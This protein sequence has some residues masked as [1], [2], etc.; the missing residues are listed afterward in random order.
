MHHRKENISYS[1]VQEYVLGQLTSECF[2][3]RVFTSEI[4][5]IALSMDSTLNWPFTIQKWK[6]WFLL[7]NMPHFIKY[8]L[9]LSIFP[10][11][12][13][14]KSEGKCSLF[15]KARKYLHLVICSKCYKY[16]VFVIALCKDLHIF[17]QFGWLT[18]CS[19]RPVL[20]KCQL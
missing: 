2:F 1:L 4:K 3:L 9:R 12:L 11:R 7:E 5:I 20:H 10:P 15:V 14:Q 13:H 16:S 8:T 18:T 19:H 6:Q 17:L